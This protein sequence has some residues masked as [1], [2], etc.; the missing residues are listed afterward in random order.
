M[1]YD[2]KEPI[3]QGYLRPDGKKGIRNKVLVIY[4]VDCSWHV[5]VKTSEYFMD[6]GHDVDVVGQHSCYHHQDRVRAL[7]SFCIH[8]NVGAVLV[9]GAGCE[10]T[11]PE[12]ICAFARKHG[13]IAEYFFLQEVGGTEKG[14][15]KAKEIVYSMIDRLEKETPRVPMY[16]DELV[17][18]GKCGGSDFTSGLAGNP[19]VGSLFDR[20][21]D[22]GATCMFAEVNEALGL[23]EPFI[24]RGVSE[25]AKKEIAEVFDKAEISCKMVNHFFIGRGN[26]EGGL[27]SIEEKS[28]SSSSKSG[29]RPIQGVLKV[30]QQPPRKGLWI[31]DET[32]DEFFR[33]KLPN[34]SNKGGDCAVIMLMNT[35][36][37]QVN[38]L[39][40]GRGHCCG[41]GI[42]PTIKIT[43]NPRTYAKM[44]DDIDINAG[45]L[46]TGEKTMKEMTDEL[47]ECII[48][49]CR[50]KAA[51][52]DRLGHREN[53]MWSVAQAFG[54]NSAMEEM[55]QE[56]CGNRSF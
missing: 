35:A 16:I 29:T 45:Q 6:N 44:S 21:V 48:D 8:P 20:L 52:A 7:L 32:P 33:Y 2:L 39:I 37:C 34:E 14:L 22:A 53:E 26:V 28:L 12:D 17:I 27:T 41:T 9:I 4:T 38:L 13:R 55:E 36:G 1:K 15:A 19:L 18:S 10:N 50:G 25:Q 43:G 23:K 46:L 56:S 24:E 11:R 42:S 5:A 54:W 40:T 51:N 31:F 49:V 30:S 3:C 47:L